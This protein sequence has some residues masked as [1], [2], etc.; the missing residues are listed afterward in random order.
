MQL[1]K[2]VFL[3][4]VLLGIGLVAFAQKEY[5]TSIDGVKGGATLKDALYTLI[6]DHTK[7]SYGSGSS[8]T[9]GAFYSTDRNPSNNQVYDMYSPEVRYFG[10]K[11][12]AISGM[13][14]EH[15]LPKSW[16]GGDKNY[17]YCDLHHLN[18]SDQ[19]ANSRKSNY[20]LAEL[21]SVAVI[22]PGVLGQTGIETAE[23]V[24]ALAGVVSA[25]AVIV[26]DALTAASV[27]RLGNTI[28]ITDSGIHPGSGVGNKRG[29]ISKNILGVPTVA[30]GVPTVV[31]A[32]TLVSEAT[33]DPNLGAPE[34][35]VTPK[36][37][38]SIIDTLSDIIALGVNLALHPEI[39]MDAIQSIM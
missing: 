19:T 17:A 18:P 8:S 28:Q 38:D 6:K 21:E 13:N 20:P 30:I 7:I 14:I 22:A 15:S 32:A 36:D 4:L 34:M 3:L 1:S 23:T 39:P 5:Y 37:I 29:E 24:K 12:N 26:I 25:S 27:T 2:R 11:G 10:T 9:W 31:N 33:G 35:I 16:W